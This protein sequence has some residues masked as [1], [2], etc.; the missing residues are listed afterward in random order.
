MRPL[1]IILEGLGFEVALEVL[2][3]QFAEGA[4]IE[5]YVSDLVVVSF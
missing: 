5:Y 3:Q 4:P 2:Y 1:I